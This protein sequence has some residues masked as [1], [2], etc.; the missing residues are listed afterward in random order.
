M[1]VTGAKRLLWATASLMPITL[2]AALVWGTGTQQP[3]DDL[4][5]LGQT[6]TSEQIGLGQALYAQNCAS[7]H[8][9][10]LEGQPNWRRRL[11]T[12]RMPA[13]PHDES[14]H[15]WHHSDQDL[16]KMTKFGVGA[17]IPGYES[18]MPAFEG[19]LSDGQIMAV[20]TYIKSRWPEQIQ[21]RQAE[22]TKQY[23]DR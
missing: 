14:G 10:N 18:D 3:P 1:S 7:C 15:T 13:P 23:R 9:A 19:I 2:V 5:F 22:I 4:A 12:G 20:L 8:G 16:F 11:D 17:V 6:V 21:A